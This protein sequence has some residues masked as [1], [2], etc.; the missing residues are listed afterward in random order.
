MKKWDARTEFRAIAENS[1]GMAMETLKN[2]IAW[3][4]HV[5]DGGM[6]AADR[7]VVMDAC[8]ECYVALA[9]IATKYLA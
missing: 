8:E 9:P 7:A 2:M 1:P 5:P 6:D 3:L 4:E